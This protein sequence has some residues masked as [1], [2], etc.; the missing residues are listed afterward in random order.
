MT[1]LKGLKP[2]DLKILK[3]KYTHTKKSLKPLHTNIVIV[4]T[5]IVILYYTILYCILV[6]TN[7]VK[8]NCSQ[9]D[10]KQHSQDTKSL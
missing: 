8:S 6:I 9:N 3:H 4:I 10:I 1:I 7:I 2:C 5:N